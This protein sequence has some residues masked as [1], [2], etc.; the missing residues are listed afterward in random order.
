MSNS[1]LH[2]SRSLGATQVELLT[3]GVQEVVDAVVAALK[4]VPTDQAWDKL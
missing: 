4:Q 2:S 3:G 1:T